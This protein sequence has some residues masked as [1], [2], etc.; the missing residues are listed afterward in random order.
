MEVKLGTRRSKIGSVAESL[1]GENSRNEESAT[2]LPTSE[3]ELAARKK[4]PGY[5][6][7][8]RTQTRSPGKRTENA[9]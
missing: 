5:C 2:H 9:N 1:I 4:Q 3:K 7:F 6:V 8:G